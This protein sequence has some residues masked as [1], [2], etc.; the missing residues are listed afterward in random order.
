MSRLLILCTT[1]ALLCA[2]DI[3]ALF[4]L[5][6]VADLRWAHAA[7]TVHALHDAS[8]THCHAIEADVNFDHVTQQPVMAHDADTPGTDVTRWL[9]LLLHLT[10]PF[11]PAA[12][13]G[14]TQAA[15]LKLDF[16]SLHAV[17]PTL[18][19]LT[20]ALAAAPYSPNKLHT[21]ADTNPLLWLNADI[22]QGPNG[23]PSSIDPASFLALCRRH[24]PAAVLS[25]GWTTAAPPSAA[26][27][28]CA[29]CYT[30]EHVDAMLALCAQHALAAVTFPVRACYVRGAWE[31]GQMRRLLEAGEGYTLTVW[32]NRRENDARDEAAVVEEYEWLR[33]SLPAHR[34][35]F[36]LCSVREIT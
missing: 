28:A 5:T 24:H 25:I 20:S 22:L 27:A 8:T 4:H 26:S 6:S 29:A 16:K 34:V 36:D 10:P 1:V 12:S 7:N 17:A 35:F 18:T 30:A 11:L 31:G 2:A 3:C 32:S 23:P 13:S 15:L 33:A 19:A 14:R 9:S 21:T